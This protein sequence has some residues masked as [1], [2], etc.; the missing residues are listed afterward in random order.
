MLITLSKSR[1]NTFVNISRVQTKDED[2]DFRFHLRMPAR[3]Y[4]NLNENFLSRLYGNAFFGEFSTEMT[5]P[6]IEFRLSTDRKTRFSVFPLIKI[7]E[8]NC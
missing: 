2:K 1:F 4:H 5:F 7:K 3:R 6:T 8:L